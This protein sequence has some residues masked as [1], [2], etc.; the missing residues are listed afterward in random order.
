MFICKL[1][2][3]G[4]H[5]HEP[6]KCPNTWLDSICRCKK[7]RTVTT[8]LGVHNH[9]PYEGPGLTCKEQLIG[10]CI[11]TQVEEVL[12]LLETTPIEKH[13]LW[14]EFGCELAREY[15]PINAPFIIAT[16]TEVIE[17]LKEKVKRVDDRTLGSWGIKNEI[18]KLLEEYP[19]N[20]L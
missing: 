14:P 8:R 19:I 20:D 11:A 17:K 16:R 13:C 1:C 12:S 9:G 18:L 6:S 5:E 10:A 3:D 15:M 7:D 2:S 4:I